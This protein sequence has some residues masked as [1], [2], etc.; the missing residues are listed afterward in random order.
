MLRQP[1]PVLADRKKTVWV[2]GTVQY[3]DE[4]KDKVGYDV[5][6]SQRALEAMILRGEYQKADAVAVESEAV[7]RQKK[8]AI[9]RHE[10]ALQ[11]K[12]A[13]DPAARAI[14]NEMMHSQMVRES[15]MMRLLR[16][17]YAEMP[18]KKRPYRPLTAND[19]AQPSYHQPRRIAR[20]DNI[21][22]Y[23]LQR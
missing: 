12:I 8:K 18:R 5:V 7:M 10:N 22:A 1:K 16:N 3:K 19:A 23:A 20:A 4:E 11:K 6:R 13:Q 17:D 9:A 14:R 21:V 15:E 2:P